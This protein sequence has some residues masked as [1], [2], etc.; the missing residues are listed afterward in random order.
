M[1][2]SLV[3][4]Q[5]ADDDYP[6]SLFVVE[7]VEVLVSAEDGLYLEGD[8]CIRRSY[9]IIQLDDYILQCDR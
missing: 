8:Y 7:G 1:P 6:S 5:T 2:A 3:T 4:L 9:A